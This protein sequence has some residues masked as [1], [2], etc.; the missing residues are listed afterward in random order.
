MIV[1]RFFVDH[2]CVKIK[3][4]CLQQLNLVTF[5]DLSKPSSSIVAT[6]GCFK[7]T[8]KLQ[9]DFLSCMESTPTFRRL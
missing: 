1:F 3:C 4:K 8:Q 7:A 6:D 2:L 5:A 9:E